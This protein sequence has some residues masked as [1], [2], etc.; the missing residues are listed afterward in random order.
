M[1]KI[2]SAVYKETGYVALWVAIL[3][4]ILQAVF[5]VCRRWTPVILLDNL[6]TAAFSV[7]NFFIMGLTVQKAVNKSEQQAASMMKVS[8]MLRNLMM[9]VV[10]VGGVLI[11]MQSKNGLLELLPNIIALFLPAFFPRFAIM[12]R[13]KMLK[14]ESPERETENSYNDTDDEDDEDTDED[15][16]EDNEESEDIDSSDTDEDVDSSDIDDD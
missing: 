5:L 8:Q 12:V 6:V 16:E 10:I 13:Y 14:D 4:V 9:A 1:K 2:S 3:S 7:L 15:D 11:H